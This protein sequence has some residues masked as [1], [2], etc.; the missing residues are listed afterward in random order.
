MKKI[1]KK[2]LVIAFL[3]AL[4]LTVSVDAVAFESKCDDLRN[5]VLRLH[6]LANS[7]SAK[8]QELKLLVRDAVINADILSFDKCINLSE[9]ITAAENNKEKILEI[10]K[11]VI[12]ENGFNYDV[13]V[14]IDKSYFNTREYEKFTL[15]AGIY[16]A[17]VVKIGEA[18]GKNWWCV[19]FPALCLPAATDASLTECVSSDTAHIATEPQNYQIRFKTVEIY[20]HI[21]KILL[22]K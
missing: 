8:D 7:D 19:M 21:K 22:N 1:N 13:T 5:N 15:P 4:V 18:K 9:A 12:R 6:I 3:I 2:N 10:V 11:K 20:Q 17:L 14:Q 16:N